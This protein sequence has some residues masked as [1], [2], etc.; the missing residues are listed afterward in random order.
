MA[1]WLPA[2]K[3]L[4]SVEKTLKLLLSDSYSHN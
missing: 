3:A 2:M 1:L 4:E